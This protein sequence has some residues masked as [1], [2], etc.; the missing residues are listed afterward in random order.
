VEGNTKDKRRTS[1]HARKKEAIKDCGMC[2]KDL[3]AQRKKL[4]FEPQMCSQQVGDPGEKV[5]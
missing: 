5:V 2:Q 1:Y 4:Q 3:G